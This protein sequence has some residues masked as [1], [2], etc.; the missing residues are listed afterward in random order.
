MI[1]LVDYWDGEGKSRV[2]E[3]TVPDSFSKEPEERLKVEVALILRGVGKI[4]SI[5]RRSLTEPKK[6]TTLKNSHNRRAK[7]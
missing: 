2:R 1:L 7:K 6:I 3:I 4:R 5:T